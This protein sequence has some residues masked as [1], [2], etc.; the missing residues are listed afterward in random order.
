MKT[1]H[2]LSPHYSQQKP[3]FPSPEPP[4][5]IKGSYVT[6][7]GKA[8]IDFGITYR[9]GYPEFTAEGF[10]DGSSGQCVDKIRAAYM[11]DL[12]AYHLSSMWLAMHCKKVAPETVAGVAEYAEK[13]PFRSFYDTQAERFLSSNGLKLRVTLS[14]TKAPAWVG[15]GK[16]HG[17]H[18]RVTISRGC[19]VPASFEV[20]PLARNQEAGDRCTCGTCG[21][22]WDDSLSTSHTPSPSGRC[23]FEAFHGN[24]TRLTFD[25]WGSI[26]D[27]RHLKRMKELHESVT[28]AER[29]AEGGY[30]HQAAN[31][32]AHLA[33]VKGRYESLLAEKGT[34]HP[35]AYDVLSCIS[36][37][38]HCPDT[39][40]E[41]CGEF[42]YDEDSIKATQLFNRCSAF[43]KR[44]QAFFTPAEL[45]QLAEIR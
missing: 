33:D 15:A 44:L 32:R 19:I 40:A 6:P 22:S 35:S 8:Q 27:A 14:D 13:H 4:K 45:E 1:R 17:H 42:G 25:F 21:L 3:L 10:F 9:N 36:G 31:A 18:Y 26:A 16:D 38:A 20:K 41:F 7:D 5:E 43:A 24:T 28:N 23:P 39:F 29:L 2:P 34:G 30:G 12:T 11:D 37:D